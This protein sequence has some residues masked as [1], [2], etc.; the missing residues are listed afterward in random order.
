MVASENRNM[1]SVSSFKKCVN[2]VS[3]L[4]EAV[5]RALRLSLKERYEKLGRQSIECGDRESQRL[6]TYVSSSPV[7]LII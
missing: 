2:A 6:L 4:C 3:N 7:I 5:L 1:V